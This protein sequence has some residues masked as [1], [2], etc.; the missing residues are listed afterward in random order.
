M[1][2]VPLIRIVNAASFAIAADRVIE[3]RRGS[4]HHWGGDSDTRRSRLVREALVRGTAIRH[5]HPRVGIG[6]SRAPS[7]SGTGRSR[8]RGRRGTARSTTARKG[9]GRAQSG[10]GDGQQ[11]EKN[12]LRHDSELSKMGMGHV[13]PSPG[14]DHRRGT[15]GRRSASLAIRKT[16]FSEPR[17][18]RRT[19]TSSGNRGQHRR[20]VSHQT[21]NAR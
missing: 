17:E 1:G 15:C 13:G 19:R 7:G 8:T 12:G 16:S 20:N 2:R 14:L 9:F 21:M 18:L 11:R 6:G 3:R 5:V 10:T 4:T